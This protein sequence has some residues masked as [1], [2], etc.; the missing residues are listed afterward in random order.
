MARRKKPFV[1]KVSGPTE[2]R[3]Y[4]V[5][6]HVYCYKHGSRAL[7]RGEITDFHIK[8]A[9]F[10]FLCEVTQKY[11][12]ALVDDIITDPDRKII[13]KINAMAARERSGK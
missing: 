11:H 6:Q 10:T 2:F 9:A 5:G 7:G 1:K 13:N 12:I 8:D 3:G 4:K